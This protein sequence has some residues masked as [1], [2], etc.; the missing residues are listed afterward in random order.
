MTTRNVRTRINTFIIIPEPCLTWNLV[1]EK[2][3]VK[4]KWGS[5][6]HLGWKLQSAKP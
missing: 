1:S 4:Q 2:G 3:R 5:F 6:W